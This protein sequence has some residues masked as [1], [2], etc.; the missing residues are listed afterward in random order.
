MPELVHG[1]NCLLGN[2]KI[3]ILKLINKAAK[4]PILR[5][6]IGNNARK[7]YLKYYTPEKVFLKILEKND[8]CIQ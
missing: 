6:K 2:N 8:N 5:K 1:H 3:E 7:T 4:S